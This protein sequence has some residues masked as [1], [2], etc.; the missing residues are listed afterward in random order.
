VLLAAI[1]GALI[2]SRARRST[3]PLDTV[4]R[5]FATRPPASEA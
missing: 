4:E 5:Y 1:E 2:L 3:E